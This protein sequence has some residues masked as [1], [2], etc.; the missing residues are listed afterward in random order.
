MIHAENGFDLS[1][2]W[3]FP[4]FR[5]H[6]FAFTALFVLILIIYGNSLSGAWIFDDFNSIVNNPGVHLKTLSWPEIKTAFFATPQ[7]IILN[8]SLAGLS[9]ALNYYAS[10]MN[11]LGYH[12]VNII[13]HLIASFFLY[14]LIYHTL[15][16]PLLKE[17]YGRCAYAIALL[18]A[19]LWASSPLH[20]NAVTYI[21]QRMT[22]LTAMA[23]VMAMYFYLKGR[24]AQ[25]TS[26]RIAFFVLCGVAGVMAIASKENAV[27][28]PFV[29]Y[30]Y[31]LFLIQGVSTE[32]IRKNRPIILLILSIAIAGLVYVIFFTSILDYQ[33]WT[34]SMKE[35]LLTA[36]R[37]L[38]FY[39]SLLLYPL[40]SRLTLDHDIQISRS[41]IDPW[42]TL[43]AILIIVCAIGYALWIARRKPLLSFCILFFFLNH[44]VE[45]TIIPL[46]LVFEHRNYL[47]AMFFFVPVAIFMITVLDYF[48]YKRS[49]QFLMFFVMTFLLAAQ[50]HTVSARNDFYQYPVILWK[51]NI[52]KYPNLSRPHS[53]LGS[54]YAVQGD[55]A[56]AMMENKT[57]LHLSRYPKLA[58]LAMCHANIGAFYVLLNDKM[59]LFHFNEALR[60]HPG[61]T[62]PLV[63]RNMALIMLNRG[64]L[65]LAHEYSQ[66]GLAYVPDNEAE[67]SHSNLALILLKEEN[68]EEAIK[69]AN[70]AVSL[71]PGLI[72]PL[73]I[74]GEAYRLK[75]NYV[76]SE[77]YWREVLKKEPNNINALLALSELYDL[78]GK[79][80]ELLQ[81][82][83]KLLSLSR[84]GDIFNTIITN[85]GKA[86][87]YNPDP[88][89]LLPILQKVF[90]Q[91]VGDS[92]RSM[93]HK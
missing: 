39:I 42:S 36:P 33:D 11:V 20:V 58:Q 13:I 72:S 14:L 52:N 66:R 3:R 34:F 9:F 23:C 22:S 41:L 1:V 92:T 10:G 37:I 64:D 44:L 70:K 40:N 21:V 73:R 59:A 89:R 56:K 16:L 93:R 30:L 54:V 74:L 38:L 29:I 49:L 4:N 88:K 18:A 81:T 50:G 68:I 12:L 79:K 67:V 53:E 15:N 61:S 19:V 77:Y 60:L 6:A 85:Q 47:P 48:A 43:P 57:A 83:G 65:K 45:G 87:A 62:S 27:T 46:D 71:R 7:N 84:N 5:K 90:L 86:F 25:D 28:L 31:D 8:R 51:D 76:W 26:W 75:G 69:A 35:R 78:L 32:T 55:Y 17:K 91:L 2:Q 63:Y 82:A 24:T 80:E